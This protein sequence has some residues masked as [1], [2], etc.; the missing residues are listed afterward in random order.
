MAG[1]RELNLDASSWKNADDFYDAFFKAV[2][3]PNGTA[4]ISTR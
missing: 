2:G 3:A 1:M 4:E